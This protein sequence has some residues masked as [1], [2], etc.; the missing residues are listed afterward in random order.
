[1]K[2][3]GNYRLRM[4]ILGV[5]GA[6]AACLL[7]LAVAASPAQADVEQPDGDGPVK[8]PNVYLRAQD[9]CYWCSV[10]EPGEPWR[11]ED[12]DD[13]ME[14]V[15]GVGGWE[16]EY[17]ETVN[18]GTGTDGLFSSNVDFIFIEGSDEGAYKLEAFLSTHGTAL[19]GW[20]DAGGRLI[21]NAATDESNSLSF[22]GYY[23]DQGFY[24]GY[25]EANDPTHTIFNGPYTPI[26]DYYEGDAFGHAVIEGPGI[27][28]LISTSFDDPARVVLGEYRSGNGITLLGGMT[29][30][31]YHSAGN[32]YNLRANIIHYTANVPLG[33]PDDTTAPVVDPP[34]HGFVTNS[35]LGTSAIPV[36][37]AWS[38]DDTAVGYQLQQSTNGGAYQD[39]ALPSATTTSIT[40]SLAPANNYQFRVRAQDQVGNW[41]D[42]VSGSSFKIE[43]YQESDAAISY[44]KTWSRQTLSSAYGG[45]LKYAKGTGAEKATFAFRG[46][47]VAWVAPRNT[48][49]GKADVYL[50]GSKA[51]TID[52]Y[53][54]S[55][56]SRKVVFTKAG[57][58]ASVT[59]TLEVRVLGSKNAASSGKRVDVDAF[60]ALR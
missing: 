44:L 59:H 53:A 36:K 15:F 43:A 14:R 11:R 49:R 57:L 52:L 33:P 30:P 12:N 48:N 7:V 29:M 35:T 40:H 24:S 60:V 46:S 22:D 3:Q 42:W 13:A 1:M 21:I 2:T 50:D 58:D 41:S 39:V 23:F 16:E 47:E 31:Y 51:A 17:F 26:S 9:S 8:T 56:Q 55:G 28:P 34:T 38:A 18:I 37:L 20:V 5:T 45:A 4:L 54:A 32:P 25:V 27:T 19:E 10:D 6:L